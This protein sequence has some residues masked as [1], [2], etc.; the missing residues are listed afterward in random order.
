MLR[1]ISHD[2]GQLLRRA[3]EVSMWGS[4]TILL[5]VVIAC[6]AIP[7]K[8]KTLDA[9]ADGEKKVREKTLPF[10]IANDNQCWLKGR[11]RDGR[12]ELIT[13]SIGL[14]NARLNLHFVLSGTQL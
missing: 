11:Y 3:G 13:V 8:G 10:E 12:L 4:A 7:K 9:S 14:S 2:R 1:K 5:A 6:T